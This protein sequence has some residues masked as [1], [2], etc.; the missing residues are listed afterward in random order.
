M[1]T[2]FSAWPSAWLNRL[3]NGEQVKRFARFL[4]REDN[5][6]DLE[7]GHIRI[8]YVLWRTDGN[9]EQVV[10]AAHEIVNEQLGL[11]PCSDATKTLKTVKASAWTS[12]RP[13]RKWKNVSPDTETK[14]E[15]PQSDSK[16]QD[17]D[18]LF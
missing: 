3:C 2:N 1:A 10:G 14:S 5:L 18:L 12:K 16:E 9:G 13:A 6:K 15:E 11:G 4:L 17:D 8:A 7:D